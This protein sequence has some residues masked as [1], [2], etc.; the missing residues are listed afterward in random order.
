MLF[1]FFPQARFV[2]KAAPR[3][4]S[5]LFR[6]FL[7]HWRRLQR[8]EDMSCCAKLQTHDETNVGKMPLIMSPAKAASAR[9]M[10][11]KLMAFALTECD[12]VFDLYL[13]SQ[14]VF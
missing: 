7:M 12:N 8:Q 5:T 1:A 2:Q 11:V 9:D 10:I 6:L 13:F 3:V 14:P 4:L